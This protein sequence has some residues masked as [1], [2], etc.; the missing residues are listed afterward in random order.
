[1]GSRQDFVAP[2]RNK[3]VGHHDQG[4]EVRPLA[5]ERVQ[6]H[7]GLNRLAE[8]NLVGE[9]VSNS[10]IGQHLP[11]VRE[12]MREERRGD[13]DRGSQRRTDAFEGSPDS[14]NL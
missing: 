4:L 10:H 6:H 12:L 1:M 3:L 13:P 7:Q 8:S 5:P 14:L 9:Q 11:H 2:L